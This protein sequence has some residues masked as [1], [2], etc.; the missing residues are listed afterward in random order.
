MF[1]L[2]RTCI[3]DEYAYLRMYDGETNL[4]IMVIGNVAEKIVQD[5]IRFVRSE[6]DDALSKSGLE[7]SAQCTT[8]HRILISRF[9]DE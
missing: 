8:P 7:G 1:H 9:V 2:Y 5:L 3:T 6:L 4:E